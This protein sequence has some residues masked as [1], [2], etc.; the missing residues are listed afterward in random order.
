MP[1]PLLYES[2]NLCCQF[3]NSS[4][5][6]R[7][8]TKLQFQLLLLTAMIV[9]PIFMGKKGPTLAKQLANLLLKL[10]PPLSI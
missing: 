6:A 3:R 2:S 9:S 10:Q 1:V 4:L 5:E 8:R 7:N